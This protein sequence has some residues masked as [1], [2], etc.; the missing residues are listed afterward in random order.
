MEKIF[1]PEEVRLTMN[2]MSLSA[3]LSMLWEQ[4]AAAYDAT[5]WWAMV[6]LAAF[7]CLE[8]GLVRAMSSR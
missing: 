4:T 8:I 2:P 6:L 1:S 3:A 7:A 5:P